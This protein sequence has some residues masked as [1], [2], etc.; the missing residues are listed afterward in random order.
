MAVVED[1]EVDL[2]GL[3]IVE[4]LPLLGGGIVSL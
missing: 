4:E 2:D 3:G 1:V